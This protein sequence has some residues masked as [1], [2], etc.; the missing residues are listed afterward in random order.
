MISRATSRRSFLLGAFAGVSAWSAAGRRAFSAESAQLAFANG[1]R[2][3]A[4]YPGKRPLIQLSVRPPQ[5]ETPFSIFNEGVLTPNDAFFVRYHLADIPLSVDPGAF[6]LEIRGHVETPLSLSLAELKR[7]FDPVEI[8]AVNQC[9]GNSRGFVEPRVAGGQFGN[10]AMGNAR[11][12]G[13]ALKAILEKAGPK[14]V[15]RSVAFNGLDA[16]VAPGTPDFVKSLDLDHAGDGEVMLAYAMNGEDLPWL[17]GFPLRL[18]VPGCYGT[19]WVKHLNEIEVLDK[20][21]DGFWM[22]SAYRIPDNDCAC[23]APGAP[24]GATRPIKRLNVRSFITSPAENT[25]VAAN[26]SFEVKGVAFDGG[27]GVEAVLLSADDGASWIATRLG[28]DLGRY[29][30][31]EWRSE[32]SLRP[33]VHHLKCRAVNRDGQSQPMAPLWNHAGYMRNVVETVRIEAV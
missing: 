8:V 24:K 15:A 28:E 27:H 10:G 32:L 29:S 12:R 13:V 33:G 3:L 1:E 4:R 30:F 5:L 7:D 26:V 20:E 17:N 11:W 14:P 16:P 23:V 18:V 25:K 2:P 31:R 6:R 21:F 9:S 19:Y 22:S